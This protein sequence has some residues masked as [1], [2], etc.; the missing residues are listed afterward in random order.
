MVDGAPNAGKRGLFRQS[1][2]ACSSSATSAAP[3]KNVFVV[4][5]PEGFVEAYA[6]AKVWRDGGQLQGPVGGMLGALQRKN[7]DTLKDWIVL[8]L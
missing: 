1:D 5:G 2:C 6:G 7:P 8:K 4:S 3:G